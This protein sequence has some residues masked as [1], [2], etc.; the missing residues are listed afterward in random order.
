M[1]TYTDVR[2]LGATCRRVM[3]R[4]VIAEKPG[5]IVHPAV[6]AFD[7]LAAAGAGRFTGSGAVLDDGSAPN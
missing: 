5:S 6:P 2:W 4:I 1:P 3:A 7:G